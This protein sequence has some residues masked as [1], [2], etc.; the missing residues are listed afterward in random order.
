MKLQPRCTLSCSAFVI[1]AFLF[2]ASPFGQ[3]TAAW[4]AGWLTAAIVCSVGALLA[5]Y[6]I[7]R[8]EQTLR[9]AWAALL[10]NLLLPTFV[11][12]CFTA[13]TW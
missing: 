8:R 11:V 3:S 9:L 13:M 1:G 5:A 10:F 12:V 6:F 7:H 4:P 2:V